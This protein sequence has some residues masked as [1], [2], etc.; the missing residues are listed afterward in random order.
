MAKVG[1]LGGAVWDCIVS[2]VC[3]SVLVGRVEFGSPSWYRVK[4]VR[5][6][7]RSDSSQ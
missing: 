1:E 6:V 7:A 3:P 2:G 5:E 4:K